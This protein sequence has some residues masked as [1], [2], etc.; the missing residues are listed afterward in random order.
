MHVRCQQCIFQPHVNF[1]CTW[2]LKC[3]ISVR[4]LHA[5]PFILCYEFNSVHVNLLILK[6]HG[7]IY[8]V[9]IIIPSVFV[10]IKQ[11]V[12]VIFSFCNIFGTSN[13][14]SL[15]M[16]LNKLSIFLKICYFYFHLNFEKH[17]FVHFSIHNV[18]VAMEIKIFI[19]P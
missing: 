12:W 2:A 5:L 16:P 10:I 9:I 8:F 14:L 15:T 19:F 3:L 17:V 6:G 1:I 4:K 11:N 18:P 13:I 7:Q